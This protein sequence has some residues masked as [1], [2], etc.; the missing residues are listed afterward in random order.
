MRARQKPRPKP[1]PPPR[2][3]KRPRYAAET[4]KSGLAGL[5]GIQ[6]P[7]SLPVSALVLKPSPT[8]RMI[9]NIQKRSGDRLLQLGRTNIG[10]PLQQAKAVPKPRQSSA[11]RDAPSIPRPRVAP[12]SDRSTSVPRPWVSTSTSAP[13]EKPAKKPRHVSL[14]RSP[15]SQRV[16]QTPTRPRIHVSDAEHAATVKRNER[17]RAQQDA[18]LQRV[19]RMEG[20]KHNRFEKKEH[21]ERSKPPPLP[22]EV[23][24]AHRILS[25]TNPDVRNAAQVLHNA[26][27]RPVEPKVRAAPT[28]PLHISQNTG[29]QVSHRNNTIRRNQHTI[30]TIQEE[31]VDKRFANVE[32]GRTRHSW[33]VGGRDLYSPPT[34]P[35]QLAPPTG[36]RPEPRIET[37]QPAPKPPPPTAPK[38]PHLETPIPPKLP[39]PPTCSIATT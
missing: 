1:R 10:Q 5:R 28:Q 8:D 16:P 37:P 22:E 31:A 9:G 15:E 13:R 36:H 38:P 26:S 25:K 24:R 3:S 4:H 14:S 18:D 29:S 23:Q 35:P 21:A 27:R 19:L 7:M 32:Y 12:R 17:H 34:V 2:P 20:L 11:P 39:P 30:S 6:H 33:V